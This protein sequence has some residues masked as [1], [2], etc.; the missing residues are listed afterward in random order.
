MLPGY[1]PV[2][3][4]LHGKG[5]RYTATAIHR[6]E[7]TRNNHEEMGFLDGWGTVADQLAEYVKTI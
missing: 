4:A 5:T 2:R 3:G 1:R 7:A 6:G